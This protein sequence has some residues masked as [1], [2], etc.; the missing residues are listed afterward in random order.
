MAKRKN[1]VKKII[2]IVAVLVAVL[3]AG[4]YIYTLEGF[5]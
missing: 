2:I 4:F 3:V 1:R 5:P